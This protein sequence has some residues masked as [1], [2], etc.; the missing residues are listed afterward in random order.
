VRCSVC[1]KRLTD[2]E[3]KANPD[4]LCTTCYRIIKDPDEADNLDSQGLD[5]L[6]FDEDLFDG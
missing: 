6:L 2:T 4:D 1:N 5:H 3:I